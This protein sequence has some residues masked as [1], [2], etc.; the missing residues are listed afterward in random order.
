MCTTTIC[1][2]NENEGMFK[3]LSESQIMYICNGE[4]ISIELQIHIQGWLGFINVSKSLT[5]I[6]RNKMS[7]ALASFSS[8][9]KPEF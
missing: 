2:L 1:S 9:R 7:N 5:A 8:L 4:Y 3:M 6:L